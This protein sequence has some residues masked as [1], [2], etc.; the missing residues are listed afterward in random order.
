M[1][2]V[3]SVLSAH[4]RKKRVLK[5]AKGQFGHRSKR[6]QQARRSLLKGMSYST[7]DMKAKK[8]DFRSLWIVRI[9]A[10]CKESGT[11]YSRFIR[12]LL[13]ANIE[14]DRKVM[15]ELAVSSP[16]AFKKLIE[17]AGSSTTTSTKAPAKTAAK[18]KK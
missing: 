10:A 2:R 9:N 18:A 17:I 7:R 13:N 16:D 8:R 1:A 5:A 4:R 12:G 15:A 14:I 6:Y 3:R 11:T